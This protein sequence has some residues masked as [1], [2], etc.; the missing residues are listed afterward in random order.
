[1]AG[2]TSECSR[3]KKK[4]NCQRLLPQEISLYEIKL[5][6]IYLVT[7]LKSNIYIAMET[8]AQNGYLDTLLVTQWPCHVNEAPEPSASPPV[9]SRT[10][11]SSS[12]RPEQPSASRPSPAEL[13][14]KEEKAR[15][16]WPVFLE[17][18]FLC[19]TW[20]TCPSPPPWN[21]LT[22]KHKGEPAKSAECVLRGNVLG[23]TLEKQLGRWCYRRWEGREAALGEDREGWQS[24][25]SRGTTTAAQSCRTRLPAVTSSLCS[26]SW[27]RFSHPPLTA[28]PRAPSSLPPVPAERVLC[29]PSQPPRGEV[30]KIN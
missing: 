4:H 25:G 20:D 2:G 10:A 14:S 17:L 5:D 6:L 27:H 18:F 24:W 15:G 21:C 11:S 12:A 1:M 19:S 26:L 29:P 23:E 28:G 13:P 7:L 30:L 8:S 9:S 16:I 3:F 22:G